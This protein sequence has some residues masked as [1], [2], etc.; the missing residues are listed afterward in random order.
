MPRHVIKVPVSG[1]YT[2]IVEDGDAL[3]ALGRARGRENR[4]GSPWRKDLVV[5]WGNATID[6]QSAD[7]I[8][9][10][11]AVS[12]PLIVLK[13]RQK[14]DWSKVQYLLGKVA[15]TQ[16]AKMLGVSHAAVRRHRLAAK[17]KSAGRYNT[18]VW[19]VWDHLLGKMSDTA[20][21]YKIGCD[22]T[23]VSLRRVKLGIP[24]YKLEDKS[25]VS[26]VNWAKWDKYLGTEP[27]AI[28]ARKIGCAEWVVRT[29][30]LKLELGG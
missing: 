21:A 4:N 20:L 7:V 3:F 22:R 17:R 29:R 10:N 5:D 12:P 9:L 11:D 28:I 14:V 27:D 6:G 16:I 1:T 26:K 23:T 13:P 24:A 19:E 2:Y 18:I 25:F 30:R 8:A 15:D